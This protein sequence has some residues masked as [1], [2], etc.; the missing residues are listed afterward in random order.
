M[1]TFNVNNFNNELRNVDDALLI[2]N[3]LLIEVAD[4]HAPV[5]RR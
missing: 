4:D 5:K 1:K 2:W 3:K